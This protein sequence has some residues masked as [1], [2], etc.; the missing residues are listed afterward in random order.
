MSNP[1]SCFALLGDR[2]SPTKNRSGQRIYRE[3]D[4]QIVEKI[5]NL[6]YQEGYTISGANKKISTEDISSPQPSQK[7]LP[8]D[9]RKAFDQI[10]KELQE[11]LE[12]VQKN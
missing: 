4:L 12:I 9:H 11:I 5:K 10:K 2:I 6:L 1:T 7:P 3:N 8:T